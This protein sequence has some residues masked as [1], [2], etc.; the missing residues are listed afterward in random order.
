MLKFINVLLRYCMS[1]KPCLFLYSELPLKNG[2]DFLDM[3][4]IKAKLN[5][6]IKLLLIFVVFFFTI[7]FFSFSSMAYLRKMKSYY[8]KAPYFLRLA[9]GRKKKFQLLM[10]YWWFAGFFDPSLFFAVT[11]KNSAKIK[12]RVLA[13]TEEKI[14]NRI[15]LLPFL[16]FNVGHEHSFLAL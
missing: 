13:F 11:R 8:K 12:K 14:R 7:K 10:L 5:R 9:R 16:S 6:L 4:Y 1:K 2:K 3:R 15:F